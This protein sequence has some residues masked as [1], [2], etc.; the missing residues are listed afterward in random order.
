MH[1]SFFAGNA[2]ADGTVLFF[3]FDAAVADITVTMLC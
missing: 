3:V 1:A 2:D